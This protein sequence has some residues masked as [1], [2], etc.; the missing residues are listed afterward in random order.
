M[1]S[2]P[3]VLPVTLPWGHPEVHRHTL[4]HL[5]LGLFSR[6]DFSSM[7]HCPGQWGA[8]PFLMTLS[9]HCF[10]V[11]EPAAPEALVASRHPRHPF[12]PSQLLVFMHMCTWCAGSSEDHTVWLPIPRHPIPHHKGLISMWLHSFPGPHVSVRSCLSRLYI[13]FFLSLFFDVIFTI[14]Q[15]E[16][17]PNEENRNF[18]KLI[19][20]F[21]KKNC[22]KSLSNW[23]K[24]R[25]ILCTRQ[26]KFF[27]SVLC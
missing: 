24:V 8:D 16:N 14:F 2:G 21:F 13:S 1:S 11:Q 12:L 20:C 18:C 7:A 5:S 6:S 23:W 25:S 15:K 26:H 9:S 10:S 19:N 3:K 22:S 17:S 4:S 27:Y